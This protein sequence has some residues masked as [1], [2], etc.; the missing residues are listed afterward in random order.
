MRKT[1]ATTVLA[2][3]LAVSAAPTAHA[4]EAAINYAATTTDKSMTIRTDTG[5]MV[6]EDGV[7]KIKDAGGKLIGGTELSFRVDDYVFPI[8]AEITD[9]TAVLTPQFDADHAKYQPVALPY[10][11][12]APWKSEYEREQAAWN[13]MVTT[14]STGATIGTLVGGIGGAAI[15]CLLGG[16]GGAVL[17][18]ALSAMFGAV[19]GAIAGCIAGMSVVGFLGTIA[20]QLLVTAPVAILAAG[21]Y[22]TTINTPFAAAK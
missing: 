2:A 4:E 6:A 21:Q 12:Q 20:G 1:A 14:I 5:S 18:G 9:R 16:G 3:A 11:N 17:T 8:A 10:E 13:R 22:F 7:F 15:G 19:P